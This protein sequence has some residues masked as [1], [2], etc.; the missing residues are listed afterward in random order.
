MA[1]AYE[2]DTRTEDYADVPW[3]LGEA[4][5]S[6]FEY[7]QPDRSGADLLD[8]LRRARPAGDRRRT[9]PPRHL[10]ELHA[11]NRLQRVVH[12][13]SYIDVLGRGRI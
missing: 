4:Y 12:R 5:P 10:P 13:K 6:L 2:P 8:R 3:W 1:E 9:V 7:P 11:Y